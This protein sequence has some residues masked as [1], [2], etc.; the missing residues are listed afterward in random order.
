ME[1]LAIIGPTA[2]GKSRLALA[3]AGKLGGEIVSID[4]RQAYCRI[5]IGTAKPSKSDREKIPHH[6]V[7][8]LELDEKN[9]AERFAHM[10]RIAV[11][12]IF[13]RTRLPILVGGSGLYLHALLNGFFEVGLDPGERAQFAESVG[14]IPTPALFR[15][16]EANDPESARRIHRN[17]RYRIVRAL[18]V[19]ALTGVPLS[20]HFRRQDAEASREHFDCRKIG[21]TVPRQI[22]YERINERTKNM[23]DGGWIEEVERLLDEG[24]D[25]G[26][27]G[28]RSLGYPEVISLVRG[29]HSR[30][31]T[32]ER[33]AR[34]TRR[35]AKRQVTW[36]RKV[37]GVVWFDALRP[38]LEER[39][40]MWFRQR[41]E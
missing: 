37:E 34:L 29:E 18:E 6:L 4:S 39:V 20:E 25:P 31:E 9:D 22:L 40:L 17:D 13:E 32:Y 23:L 33:V 11:R 14:Q 8:V 1:A 19:Y 12:D 15:R 26:W 3:L 5:D 7:D 36:F 16:L 27:P 28:L 2:V 30:Q 35:Y 38:D 41:R 24:A 21:L 10:A